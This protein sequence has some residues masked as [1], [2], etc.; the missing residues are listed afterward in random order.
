MSIRY[1]GAG[2]EAAGGSEADGPGRSAY[3]TT[4]GDWTRVAR[5]PLRDP[6]GTPSRWTGHDPTAADPAA[7]LGRR[8]RSRTISDGRA[9]RRRRVPQRGGN[10]C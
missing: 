3:R 1:P 2:D 6:H 5:F 7:R 10:P 9:G 4:A 8:G